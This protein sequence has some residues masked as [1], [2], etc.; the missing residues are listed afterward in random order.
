M[1]STMIGQT[2]SHYRI[3]EKLGGGG[4]GVVYEAEDL[5]LGRHVALKF[6]PEE[7]ASGPQ[8]LE[9]FKRE[10]RAAS[11]LNHPNICTMYDIDEADGRVFIAM[12]LLEGETLKQKIA[13]KPLSTHDLLDLAVQIAQALDAVHKNRIIHRDIKPTNIFVTRIGNAK[14]L[15]FGL[16]KVTTL[17]IGQTTGAST[18]P[19]ASTAYELLTRPGVAVGTASY[20]SP[21]QVRGEEVDTRTD[22]FSFGAVLYEMATGRPA[23]AS[24]TAAMVAHAVLVHSPPSVLRLNAELAPKLD[25]IIHKALEK[26]RRLRYQSAAEVLIDLQ[27]LKRDTDSRGV[28]PAGGRP[29]TAGLRAHQ[30]SKTIDSLA[31]L[32]FLNLSGDAEM[33]YLSDGIT[34]ALINS[35]SQL[36]KLR[37]A[38]RS[39]TFRYKGK[40]IDPQRI[41]R[42]LNVRSILTGRVTQ[43]G[44]MLLVG[45]EL[46]DVAKLSQLWGSQ[47]NRKMSDIFAL[48]EEIARE[49]SEKLRLQLT[50]EE[51]KR[52]TKRATGNKEAYED[53]L[54]GRYWWNKRNQEAMK[55]AQEC[56]QQAIAKD[57]SYALA[58]AG[59]ADYYTTLPL[60]TSGPPKA[61]FP[62]A[63]EAALKALEIDDTVAEAHAA[64]GLVKTLYDWDWPG[65]ERE[66]QRAITLNPSN[67][68]S[69]QYYGLTLVLTGRSHAA[70]AEEK[71]A[72]ELD[73]L[74]LPTNALLG[75]IFYWARQYDQAIEQERKTLDLDAN[76]VVAHW[77]LGLAYTQKCM[78]KEAVAEFESGL[79]ISPNNPLVLSQLGCA[80]AFAGKKEEAQKVLDR[81]T[82]LAKENYVS[83]WSMATMH[84]SLGEKD[85]TF[86]WLEKGF[87]D[88]STYL[89]KVYP[90]FDPLRSEP[91]FADLLQRMNLQP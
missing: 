33:D 20:M 71:R 44:D 2:I 65:A 76:S 53:Y 47:Y 15:D 59:L 46:T 32:P 17:A 4:M 38:P 29:G 51:R 57:P 75:G 30:L 12:E 45:T 26:D 68:T 62:R 13:G 5:K 49:I 61:A 14:I 72:L 34:D 11:S 18:L 22:L 82:E 27:R 66:F 60:F 74:S 91:R 89:I 87:D 69:H 79:M 88:R 21:E 10:A 80:Y 67:P 25:A 31:V 43:R 86:E 16:A 40:E 85:K 58:Y 77:Y 63:K 54:K 70:I 83:A 90:A 50:R 24:D 39:L 41:R 64:L 1:I 35:L 78:Y 6:L 23:F 19:T 3:L 9:R 52:L 36:R 7:L 8:A 48:Q 55:K 56:F 28:V 73:P 37:V 84:A 81:L 42:E